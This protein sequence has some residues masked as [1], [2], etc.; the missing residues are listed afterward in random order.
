M[1]PLLRFFLISFAYNQ[2]IE[3]FP[4]GGLAVIKFATHL[5]GPNA[6][7]VSGSALII[8]Y[9][10]TI[11]VSVASGVDAIFSLLPTW[12]LNYKLEVEIAVIVLY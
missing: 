12:W 2:V 10:L 4:S 9:V 8:D 11:A 3:L 7:V 6:G 1:Q 5:L